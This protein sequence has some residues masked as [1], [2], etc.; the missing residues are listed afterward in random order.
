MRI[1]VTITDYSWPDGPAQLADHLTDVVQAADEA[2]L[3]TVWVPDHLLQGAPGTSPEDAMLEAYT[4]LGYLAGQSSR[5]RL[6]TAV[7]AATF[8]PPALLIKAVTTLDVLSHGRAWLGIGAGYH[9][10]EAGF[11][12]LPMPETKERF[13]HLEDVLRLALQMWSGDDTP[14]SGIHH[15]LDRPINSPNSQRRPHPPILI[16]GTGEQRTLKLVA[17]YGD[18][19]NLF[20][21][22]DGGQTITHKLA[23]LAR[24]CDDVG[25]S[26]DDIQKTV[27]TRLNP[28]ETPD[29]FIERCTALAALGIDH[30]IV[31]TDGPWTKDGLDTLAAAVPALASVRGAVSRT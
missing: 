25:R 5:V 14:F 1:S 15:R 27:G 29:Q 12:G 2:G 3:D 26:Y 31:L 30:A 11:M 20:D 21:I 19:C 17:Q 16:G 22:P 8:R 6:G 24:H 10:A 7:T 28:A 4:T 18:A 9:L 13:E 23:V